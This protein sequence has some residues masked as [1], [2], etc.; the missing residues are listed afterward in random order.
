MTLKNIIRLPYNAE[1]YLGK[2]V[3]NLNWEILSTSL[4]TNELLY[5]NSSDSQIL[6]LDNDKSKQRNVVE[7]KQDR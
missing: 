2:Q 7:K 1:G 5:I 6:L 3:V 4:N